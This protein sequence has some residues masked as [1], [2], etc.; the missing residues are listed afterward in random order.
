MTK[1]LM[2]ALVATAP[3]LA[4]PAKAETLYY[5]LAGRYDAKINEDFKA[6][7]ASG[8]QTYQRLVN[9]N[10]PVPRLVYS[11]DTEKLRIYVYPDT[12][13]HAA[14]SVTLSPTTVMHIHYTTLFGE[15]ASERKVKVLAHE[16]CHFILRLPDQYHEGETIRHDCVMGD[17]VKYGWSDKF[18]E[19]CQAKVDKYYAP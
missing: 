2:W 3:L 16:L 7:F 15:Y 4:S 8:W 6:S 9:R 13:G 17:F 10:D 12:P 19:D 14:A 1:V 11:T 5:C 18:C